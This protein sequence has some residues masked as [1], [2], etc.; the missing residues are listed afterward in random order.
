MKKLF[1]FIIAVFA[2]NS[3]AISPFTY[4][5]TIKLTGDTATVSKWKANNDSVLNWASRAC[6]TMNSKAKKTSD[7][8]FSP[9]IGGAATVDSVTVAKGVGGPLKV[10]SLKFGASSKYLKTYIDTTWPC[11]LYSDVNAVANGTAR[12]VI[13]GSMATIYLPALSGTIGS[14]VINMIQNIPAAFRPT[15]SQF[16]VTTVSN[17]SQV[18]LG[19]F[20]IQNAN[21]TGNIAGSN[22]IGSLQAGTGGIP[23][24]GSVFSYYLK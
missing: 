20:V 7:S 22:P 17:A 23:A 24:Q 12:G 11:T 19:N 8:L 2:A 15:R 4:K 18:Q 3:F 6:D 16:V 21:Y 10:D 13:V 14:S 9:K 1:I 5:W